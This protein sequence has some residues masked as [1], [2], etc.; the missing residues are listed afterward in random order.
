MMN[1]IL[2]KVN[3]KLTTSF[4]F[5]HHVLPVTHNWFPLFSIVYFYKTMY[6]DQDRT[7]FQ[8]KDMQGIAVGH[9]NKT[10]AL[11][12]YNPITQKY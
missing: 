4:E 1:H 3:G 9:S 10:N 7:S 8:S 2:T 5:V 11:S 6:D 12:V